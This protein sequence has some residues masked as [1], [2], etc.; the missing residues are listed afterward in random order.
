MPRFLKSSFLCKSFFLGLCFIFSSDLF[1]QSISCQLPIDSSGVGK[2]LSYNL[3]VLVQND[4]EYINKHSMERV[5]LEMQVGGGYFGDLEEK[6]CLGVTVNLTNPKLPYYRSMQARL[7]K[8]RQ[9]AKI[10]GGELGKASYEKTVEIENELAAYDKNKWKRFSLGLFLP[11]SMYQYDTINQYSYAD[12][13]YHQRI[14][15][16]FNPK[17]M[18]QYG[19]S[20]GYDLGDIGTLSIGGTISK[21][22]QVFAVLTFDISTPTYTAFTS[23]IY[24]VQGLLYPNL[25]SGVMNLDNL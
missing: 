19:V 8:I 14:E 17:L 21:P 4:L 23:F 7:F 9:E 3:N 11:V 24:Q 18:Q 16:A 15:S 10:M 20:L 5:Y 13:A 2:I 12:S 22:R 25:R 6:A 1:S